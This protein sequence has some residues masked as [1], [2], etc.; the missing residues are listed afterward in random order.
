MTVFQHPL[1]LILA[2]AIDAVVLLGIQVLFQ[3]PEE[4]QRLRK[5]MLLA[6]LLAVANTL[7][8][9]I[10]RFAL[11]GEGGVIVGYAL[12]APLD[13]LALHF[14]GR[15]TRRQTLIALGLLLAYWIVREFAG[16]TLLS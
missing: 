9:A 7:I 2:A 3:A 14:V 13:A 16:L 8:I 5:A 1:P 11:V 15:L 4:R 6:L 10:T 12:V